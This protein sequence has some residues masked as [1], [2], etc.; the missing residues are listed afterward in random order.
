MTLIDTHTHLYS[1]KF[2]DDLHKMI[3]RAIDA[4]VRHMYLPNIDAASIKGMLALEEAFPDNCFAMMGLHP[5]HVKEDYEVELKIVE[6]WLAR[7]KFIAVGETGLD[8]YWDKTFFKE[9]KI[10]FQ[11]QLNWA[12]ELSIPIVIHARE[13]ID[14]CIEEVRLAQDGNLKGVM[15][16]FTGNTEQANRIIDLGL[17]MGLGGVLTYKNGGLDTVVKAIA[18]EHF[19]LETDAPYLAPVPFRGKRNESLYVS[20]VAQ[21]L[22]DILE[23]PIGEIAEITT[24]T[25]QELFPLPIMSV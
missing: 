11:R 12:K 13:S 21:K 17:K 1:Q 9:Q 23:R 14:Q 18:I 24:K 3:H 25:A 20:H 15:H 8:L 6:D 2:G 16:C 5:C 19:V 22:A 7:R 4:G 10:A